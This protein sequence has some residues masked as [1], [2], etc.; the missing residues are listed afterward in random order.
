MLGQSE[1]LV[2]CRAEDKSAVEKAISSYKGPV[3]L[4]LDSDPLKNDASCTNIDTA[5]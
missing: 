3:K 4:S 5:W 1:A 2:R